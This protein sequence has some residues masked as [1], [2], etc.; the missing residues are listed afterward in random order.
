MSDQ[1]CYTRFLAL[2]LAIAAVV[3]VVTVATAPA[4]RAQAATLS[5][6][7]FQPGAII[8]DAAFFNGSAMTQA[9]IQT[10]L[11]SKEPTC[12]NSSCLS[13]LKTTTTSKAADSLCKAYQGASNETTAAILYKVQVACG[14]SAKV[15]LATL[16]KEQGLVSSTGPTAGAL[17]TAMGYACPDTAPCNTAYYGIFNQ[18]YNAAHQFQNYRANPSYFNFAANRTSNIQYS[19]N[20]SCGSLRVLVQNAATAALYNYT[21]YTPNAAALSNLYGVGNSCSAYGN[22]NFWVFYNT[23]FGAGNPPFGAFDQGAVTNGVASVSGWAIDPVD[24]TRSLMMQIS[25]TNPAGTTTTTT[26]TANQNRPDVGAVYPYAKNS[27]GQTLHGFSLTMPAAATGQYGFCVTAVAS[28]INSSGNTSLGCKYQLYGAASTTPTTT[29]LAGV[30]RWETAAAISKAAFPTPGVPV[31]YIASGQT[32]ADGLSAAPAAAK[33]GGPVLFV[34]QNAIPSATLA[35]LQRI[36]PA[37]IVVVGGTNAVSSSVYAKLQSVQ[38][39]ITRI[40]GATRYQTSLMIAQSAFPTGTKAFLATGVDYPDALAAGAAAGSM[41]APVLLVNGA[42]RST[43]SALTSRL[44]SMGAKSVYVAGGTN[45]VS[46]ASISGV[47]AIGA[48]VT[49]YAGTDRYDTS[50]KIAN[51]FY[52][53]AATVYL[54]SGAT[55]PD[56]LAGAVLAG[57]TK[58]PLL[59]TQRQCVP[60]A[61]GQVILRMGATTV[62]LFGGTSALTAQVAKLG[63][64][65]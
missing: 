30:E 32:F 44:K 46:A 55:Y 35:E 50:T 49:R 59:I 42:A 23:W 9:Q 39:S 61:E 16:E 58:G 27:A 45:A 64:C 43:D 8:S 29:R 2:L 3:G 4:E 7:Q 33:Q 57:R 52:T 62:T 26:V 13:I 18:L 10:F 11:N 31:A 6:S 38:K 36:K 34:Q 1:H 40:G 53:K 21:P 60:S 51:A 63:V 15:L 12:S 65:A 24:P 25:I 28:P 56:A 47:S 5:G 20:A 48:T 22:R 54:A 37:R 19:P 14:V 17:Q 41:S